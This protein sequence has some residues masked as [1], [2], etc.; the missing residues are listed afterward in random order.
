M[1]DPRELHG[2]RVGLFHQVKVRD[3]FWA[4]LH[5]GRKKADLRLDDREGG[6][7]IGDV[8]IMRRLVSRRRNHEEMVA[9]GFDVP[10]L[11]DVECAEPGCPVKLATYETESTFSEP[12]GFCAEHEPDGYDTG[13]PPMLMRITHRLEGGQYGLAEGWAM[14]SLEKVILIATR[15]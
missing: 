8:L 7:Q 3:E 6:Y 4:D 9:A 5:E 15:N 1:L 11:T 10:A 2:A 13:T 12:T 14:L